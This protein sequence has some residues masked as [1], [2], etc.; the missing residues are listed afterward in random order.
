MEANCEEIN[1][2]TFDTIGKVTIPRNDK[3][4]QQMMNAS[5]LA[6][7][8]GKAG[9]GKSAFAKSLINTIKGQAGTTVITFTAEQLYYNSLKEAFIKANYSADLGDI[10]DIS[11]SSQRLIIWIESFEKLIESGFDG[12]VKELLSLVNTHKHIQMLITIRDYTITI[13]SLPFIS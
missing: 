2:R 13:N 1:Q 11:L 9:V 6:V 7:I 5:G 3:G 10:L 8:N 12:A 4:I